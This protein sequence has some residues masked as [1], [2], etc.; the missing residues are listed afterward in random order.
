MNP[1]QKKVSFK[2]YFAPQSRLIRVDQPVFE[3]LH[4]L[5]GK[6]Q[7]REGRRVSVNGALRSLLFSKNERPFLEKAIAQDAKMQEKT[8]EKTGGKWTEFH[9][10]TNLKKGVFTSKKSGKTTG[11]RVA[12]GGR[13]ARGV[14]D[15]ADLDV[16]E[17]EPMRR[18]SLKH[19]K[20]VA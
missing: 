9:S 18:F 13:N 11:K 8:S 16:V 5:A 3:E 2:G 12:G 10:G 14:V 6:L 15:A 7:M 20:F 1:N 17:L 4:A 19:R